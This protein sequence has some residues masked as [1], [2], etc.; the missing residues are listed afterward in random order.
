MEYVE[1]RQIKGQQIADNGIIKF[2]R[3]IHFVPSTSIQGKVYKVNSTTLE[4]SCPDYSF[5]KEPCK[6]AY[7][8]AAQQGKVDNSNVAEFPRTRHSQKWAIYN[9]SQTSEK[10]EFLRLLSD[11]TRGIEEPQQ[12]NGRPALSLADMT[13]AIVYK[14]Y[15]QMSSRRFTTDLEA[16]HAQGHIDELPHYNSLIRYMD[17]ESLAPILESLIEATAKPLSALETSFAVD[18]TGMSISN[19]V[20]WHRAKHQDKAMLERKN[21][22]KLHC[23]VGCKTNVYLVL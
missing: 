23:A 8:V 15:S 3:G 19:S 17:K 20:S 14:V 12:M 11:L 6:H 13:F 1:A 2:E 22:I 18:S 16:A 7:A 21:W 4:C 9:Q 5:R 10:R